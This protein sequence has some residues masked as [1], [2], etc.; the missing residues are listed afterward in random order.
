MAPIIAPVI[1]VLLLGASPV[2]EGPAEGFGAE[3]G[4]GAKLG[5][6][7]EV[8]L[9]EQVE[10]VEEVGDVAPGELITAVGVTVSSVM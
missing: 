2:T 10:F 3:F 6:G 5:P 8:G 1:Q 9:A 4:L 7:A